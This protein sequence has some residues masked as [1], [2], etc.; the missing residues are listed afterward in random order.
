MKD[1]LFPVTKAMKASLQSFKKEMKMA[2]KEFK[3]L[4]KQIIDA[5]SQ[6]KRLKTDMHMA[7]A[8]SAGGLV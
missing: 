7:N 6:L 8:G 3:H 5:K 4:Q 1:F 2:N